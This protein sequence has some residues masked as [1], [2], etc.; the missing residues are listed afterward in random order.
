MFGLGFG[1]V[2]P[3][4]ALDHSYKG[5]ETRLFAVGDDQWTKPSI[6]DGWTVRDL[7]DHVIGGNRF[8]VGLLAGQTAQEA[9]AGALAPGFDGDPREL[10]SESA[11]AQFD[12]F[13]V[14]GA[15][16]SVVQHPAGEISA[17][18]FLGF[19]IGE[20]L[21]HGWDLARSTGGDETMEQELIPIVWDAY[22][23]V[24]G[25]APERRTFGDGPSG[26]VP[27]DAPLWLR[28]LDASGRRP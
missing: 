23:P 8:A 20:F 10:V 9:L 17:R 13:S 12:A 18:Q 11:A 28:L 15:L 2:E 6:C 25:L 14:E 27:D 3:L 26:T 22:L 7:V 1:F 21:V 19:R 24:L 5:F 16:D 4:A